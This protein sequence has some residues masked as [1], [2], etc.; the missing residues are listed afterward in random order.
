LPSEDK[1]LV[2][3]IVLDGN[4]WEGALTPKEKLAQRGFLK[5]EL[6]KND[7]PWLWL[8][9]HFPMY[10]DCPKYTENKPLIRE[11]GP[12]IKK[13]PVSLYFSGHAHILQHLHVEGY[14][15]SFIVS[16]AGG[17]HLYDIKKSGRGFVT[18]K[19]LGFNHIH[20]T[21]EEMNVQFINAAGECLHHFQRDQA[22]RIKVLA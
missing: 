20:V 11:W 6:K 1:P 17:A 22:G 9:N 2:K 8:V 3:V 13:Y 16:G 21:T 12:L 18:N 5:A 10:S 4:Y 15:A 19:Y 14:N 7:A